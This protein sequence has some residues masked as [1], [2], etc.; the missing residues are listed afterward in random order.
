MYYIANRYQDEIRDGYLVTI[1]RKK[2][3]QVEIEI[4]LMLDMVCRKYGLA[5]FADYNTLYGAINYAGFIPWTYGIDV[6]MPRPDYHKLCRVAAIEFKEPYFFQ[7]I[8]TDDILIPI[9]KLRRSDTA[10]IDDFRNTNYNQGILVNIHPL[11]MSSD[12]TYRGNRIDE[13]RRLLIDATF[14]MPLVKAMVRKNQEMPLSKEFLHKFMAMSVRERFRELEEFCCN[15]FFDT[16]MVRCQFVQKKYSKL[17]RNWYNETIRMPFEYTEIPVPIGYERILEVEYEDN[18]QLLR[19]N[20]EHPILLFS[21]DISY[22]NVITGMNCDEFDYRNRLYTPTMINKIGDL[23]FIVDCWHGRVIYS[24][25]LDK[26]ISAWKTLADDIAAG[27]TIASDGEFYLVDD[28]EN[29]AVRAFKFFNGVFSEVQRLEIQGRPHYVLYDEK[30]DKFYIVLSN[31]GAIAVCCKKN[32]NICVECTVCIIDVRKNPCYIRSMSIIDGYMYMG[33]QFY[34]G[35]GKIYKVKFINSSWKIIDETIIPNDISGLNY[36]CKMQDYFYITVYTTGSWERLPK[37]MRCKKISDIP[38]GKY[39]I[40]NDVVGLQG[41]PY[42]I[43]KIDGHY[44]ITEIDQHSGIKSFDVID[45][46]IVNVKE[47]FGW[48]DIVEASIKRKNNVFKRKKCYPL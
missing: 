41:T 10:A 11:D 18:H 29:N 30:V 13:I 9:S 31:A 27:H 8:Y 39:E 21:A 12:G 20:Q 28:S 15:H 25:D 5:Y 48:T 45:N 3:W 32:G 36:I 22:L 34:S 33:V 7:N 40:L 43:N 37:I 6:C 26:P 38:I 42:F 2:I 14:Q 44:F 35:S 23:Y 1:D 47:I 17:N 19:R 16:S 46:Q 4:L 24:D